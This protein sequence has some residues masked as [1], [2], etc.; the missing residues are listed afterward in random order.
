[1]KIL[2]ISAIIV[3]ASALFACQGEDTSYKSSGVFETTEIIVSSEANGK[4]LAFDLHEGEQISQGAMV[5]RVDSTSLGLKIKQLKAAINA[6]EASKPDIQAQ[7]AVT[8][9]EIE[10]HEFERKRLEKL[11]AGDVATQKQLDD[12][13]AMLAVLKARLRSQKSNLATSIRSINAQI[14]TQQVQIEQIQDQIAKC[15]VIA[16]IDGTVLVK[17]SEAGE[18]TGVGKPLF[19][20]ANIDEMILRAYVTADQLAELKIGQQVEVYSELGKAEQ[21]NYTGEITWI[22][23]KSEFTPKTIQTQD[24]RANLVYAVK[25]RVPNDGY[26]KIGM[27]GGFTL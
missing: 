27:Y 7:I 4:I 22:S 16:P 1:M 20:M 23:S 15:Q 6:L 12:I 26:L 24:E 2:N 5:C 9:R 3:L 13:S 19:K 17:Y 18:M 21:R 10:K 25:V 14:I 11:L 8:E